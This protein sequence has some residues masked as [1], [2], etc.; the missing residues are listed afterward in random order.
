MRK[1]R[2]DLHG[3]INVYKEAGMTSFGV[4]AAVRR[5]T[6]VKK[7]GHT[8]TLD[9]MAEGVLPICLGHATRFAEHLSAGTKGYIAS[10]VF[11][12]GYDSFDVTGSLISSSDEQPSKESVEN[13]LS[14][15]VGSH[16]LT[17]PAFSAKKIDGE[18]AY[19]LARKGE[20]ADAGT[21]LMTM[22]S[23][24]LNSY[25]YPEGIFSVS[26]AKG[27][28]V[29]SLIHHMGQIVGVPAAMSG[30]IRSASGGFAAKDTHKLAEIE[31]FVKE[32]RLGDI[33]IPVEDAL[34][35]PRAVVSPEAATRLMNGVSPR[36]SGY[37]S[38]PR[39]AKGEECFI[40]SKEGELLAYGEADN[41]LPIKISKVFN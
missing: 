12:G 1:G 7:C 23:I 28:Y 22:Y 15:L 2:T 8:G 27:T 31:S 32:G 38:L 36:A 19:K 10:F 3:V 4:V 16:E 34:D 40:M 5:L 14:S 11:G 9:P 17:V 35:F 21:A 41:T 24:E 29:R 39:L 30:L 37:I 6:G 33:L 18:R 13:A 20:I 25:A 26:C